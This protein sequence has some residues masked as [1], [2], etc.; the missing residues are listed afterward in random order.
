MRAGPADLPML[1]ESPGM[2]SRFAHWGELDVAVE[3]QAAGR[4]ATELF[5][6]AFTDGRCPVPHW[7]YLI[8][9]RMRIKYADHE[10][11]IAAGEAWYMAPGHIPVTEA[12]VVNVVFT[13]AGEYEKVMAAIGRA[14][15]SGP[16]GA[17]RPDPG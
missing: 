5:H 13:M 14:A 8:S 2:S 7:G 10:D 16:R 17:E 3:T 15:A 1:F 6:R 11:V 9:G 4:D 12:D